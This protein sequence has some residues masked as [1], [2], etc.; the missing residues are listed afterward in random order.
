MSSTTAPFS[1]R[2]QVNVDIGYCGHGT[3][4]ERQEM[5]PE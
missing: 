2:R 4:P 1:D 5:L 3:L